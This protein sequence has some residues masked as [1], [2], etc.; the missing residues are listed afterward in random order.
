MIRKQIVLLALGISVLLR[1]DPVE[2][3]VYLDGTPGTA[4]VD[5]IV[6][7][8]ACRYIQAEEVPLPLPYT[9]RLIKRAGE[10]QRFLPEPSPIAKGLITRC[11]VGGHSADASGDL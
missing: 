1:L 9:V 5:A 4:S 11:E 8:A 3:V 2:V 6:T 10:S 7:K